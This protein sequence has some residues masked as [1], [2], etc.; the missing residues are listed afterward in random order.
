MTL[1]V[2][3]VPSQEDSDLI[4]RRIGSG[5]G[6]TPPVVVDASSTRGW[7]SDCRW[8]CGLRTRFSRSGQT[9]RCALTASSVPPVTLKLHKLLR[10]LGALR[11]GH[12][13]YGTLTEGPGHVR[14]RARDASLTPPL[15]VAAA[16]VAISRRSRSGTSSSTVAP[17][18][19]AA[20]EEDTSRVRHRG[21]SAT[22]REEERDAIQPS[23]QERQKS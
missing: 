18:F 1:T 22:E 10:K 21:Q 11:Y 6:A 17:W 4:C 9:A 20:C 19:W 8:W 7:G 5:V 15:V 16:A 2:V 14:Y 3:C 13:K 23:M 12:A